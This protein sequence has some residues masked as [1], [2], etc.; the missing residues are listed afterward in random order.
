[1]ASLPALTSVSLPVDASNEP[2]IALPSLP[3]SATMLFP[4]DDQTGGAPPP[5]RGEVLSPPTPPPKSKSKFAVR[6]RGWAAGLRSIT[7]RSGSVYER[8]GLFVDA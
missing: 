3:I 8:T 5:P 1:M 7:Q 2:N 6:L 4:S